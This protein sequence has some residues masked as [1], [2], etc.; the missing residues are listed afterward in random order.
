[1]KMISKREVRQ[2]TMTHEFKIRTRA[3]QIGSLLGSR[4]LRG[5]AGKQL[6]QL[7]VPPS[8]LVEQRLCLQWWDMRAN[9]GAPISSAQRT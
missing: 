2:F 5:N 1:M 7:H 9:H 3:Q 6:S 8:A 4:L